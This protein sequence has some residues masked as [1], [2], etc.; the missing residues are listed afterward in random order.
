MTTVLDLADELHVAP[1]FMLELVLDL[2]DRTDIDYFTGEVGPT[3][4]LVKTG[5]GT[6]WVDKVLTDAGVESLRFEIAELAS[7]GA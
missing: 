5:T 4:R 7:G 3:G 6:L 1:S 2:A